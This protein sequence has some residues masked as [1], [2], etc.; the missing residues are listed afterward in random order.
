MNIVLCFEIIRENY[1]KYV[2]TTLISILENNRKN[3]INFYIIS[4]N[5]KKES[6]NE[7]KNIIRK[8]NQKFKFIKS[9][10]K[11]QKNLLNKMYNKNKSLL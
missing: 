8:Y 6:E 3:K 7:I 10:S 5:L 2:L 4:L 9:L 1:F 11:K